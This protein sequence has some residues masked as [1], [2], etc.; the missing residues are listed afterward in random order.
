M[1]NE[2]FLSYINSKSL[3]E[4]ESI[5]DSIDVNKYQDRVNL[6]SSLIKEK[7]VVITTQP[8]LTNIPFSLMCLVRIPK[9]EFN[10]STFF[11]FDNWDKRVHNI[12]FLSI[13]K[14]H[15]E[16][17]IEIDTS[18][19][20]F[21]NKDEYQIQ[22]TNTKIISNSVNG[23]LEQQIYNAF[24]ENQPVN[25]NDRK[26]FMI[27]QIRSLIEKIIGQD[28]LI[29][30][31]KTFTEKLIINE[32]YKVWRFEYK[33]SFFNICKNLSISIDS[34]Q[35]YLFNKSIHKFEY[36]LNEFAKENINASYIKMLKREIH[37]QFHLK[38][39]CSD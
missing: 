31:W 16:K 23:W 34:D 9:N 38:H 29:N 7:E 6:I 20:Q 37:Y 5:L 12:L 1:E 14:L 13:M 33:D 8:P 28:V 19:N 11:S 17:I 26:P 27:I 25:P 30:P 18:H 35:E 2:E 32:G 24:S 22:S 36:H 10:L 39:D 4:L 21:K 15:L 3:D